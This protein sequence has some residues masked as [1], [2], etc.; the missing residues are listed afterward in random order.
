MRGEQR[1]FG[2]RLGEAAIQ[3][4]HHPGDSL[5]RRP[6]APF[7]GSQAELLAKGGLDA[8][9]IKNLA[10]ELRSCHGFGAHRV[11]GQL[12]AIVFPEMLD[13]ARE[14]AGFEQKLALRL[15]QAGFVPGEMGPVRL[16][17]FQVMSDRRGFYGSVNNAFETPL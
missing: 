10:L 9:A 3:I 17:Q 2:K 12:I 6:R 5:F 13:R 14:F 15:L 16:C 7:V 11:R 8:R 4:D 1:L